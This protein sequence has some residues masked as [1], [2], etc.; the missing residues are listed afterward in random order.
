MLH[1]K[2]VDVAAAEKVLQAL[3][4]IHPFRLKIQE[5]LPSAQSHAGEAGR[6]AP[7]PA[8]LEA[9][10]IRINSWLATTLALANTGVDCS[11]IV[12]PTAAASIPE[13][14]EDYIDCDAP[15]REYPDF[16]AFR[17]DGRVRHDF[18]PM[19]AAWG[20]AGG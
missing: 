3:D 16:A 11:S 5:D 4:A 13:V 7:G 18:A 9:Q 1:V 6:V 10:H 8:A 15:R 2:G 19:A 14:D 12:P 17:N 20:M